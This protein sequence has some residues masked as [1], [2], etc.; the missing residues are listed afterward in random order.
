MLNEDF[1]DLLQ[2]LLSEEAAFLVV[3]AYAMAV[4]GV[5]RATG[6]L[7][8]WIKPDPD[9]ALRVWKALQH[10]G[11]PVDALGISI[12]DL[13][14]PDMIVQIGLPPRRIDLL[15]SISGVAFDDAW[16]TRKLHEVGTL[17]V[18]FLGREALLQNKRE[19]GR[20]KDLVDVEVL[21][22]NSD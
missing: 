12:D 10:F 15:T 4:H 8:I 17:K 1:Q 22:Q 16:S 2:A 21:E 3:G 5:P 9:N 6:D 13:T 7:D 20:P 14:A 19:S 11:A 18:P